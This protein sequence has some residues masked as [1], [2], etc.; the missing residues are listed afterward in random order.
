MMRKMALLL[1][2][3]SLVLQGCMSAAIIGAAGVATKTGTDPR[4]IGTQLDDTTLELRIGSNLAQDEQLKEQARVIAVVYHN[5]IL[6]IGQT[7]SESLKQKA[8][9]IAFNIAGSRQ[10]YN[11]IR[12]GQPI[13]ITTITKDSWIT[14][15]VRSKLLTSNQVPSGNVKVITENG[16]VFLLG[17]VTEQE[18]NAAA[19]IASTISG[20][21]RVT[22]VFSYIK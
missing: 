3:I 8:Q 15:M 10:I 9:E 16:E 18:A 22:T 4:T 5:S 7:P 20:V 12:S 13:G 21:D 17:L 11:E 6:L 14:S 19:K 2:S 1:I